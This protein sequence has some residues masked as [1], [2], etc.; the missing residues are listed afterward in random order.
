MPGSA[1]SSAAAEATM[2]ESPMAVTC[3]PDTF[4]CR[5]APLWHTDG[6]A[7]VSEGESAGDA[8]GEADRDAEGEADR[9]AEGEADRD[10]EG[11]AADAVCLVG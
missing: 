3:R 8:E 1:A 6:G 10:A 11:E 7:G 9:D 2:T 5:T 4:D